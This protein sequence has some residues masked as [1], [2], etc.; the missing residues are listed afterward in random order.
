MEYLKMEKFCI[1]FAFS[2]GESNN[3][4]P[5]KKKIWPRHWK[6]RWNNCCWQERQAGYSEAFRHGRKSR[7]MIGAATF[8]SL[9]LFR[10]AYSCETPGSPDPKKS[11]QSFSS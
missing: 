4:I 6:N 1:S 9:Q 2:R 11:L 10:Q 3:K 7:A 8:L 5:T